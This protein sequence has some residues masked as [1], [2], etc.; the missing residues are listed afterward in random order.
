[1]PWVRPR[2]RRAPGCRARA[3][4]RG[5]RCGGLGRTGRPG[6]RLEQQGPQGPPR[7][8]WP[9]ARSRPARSRSSASAYGSGVGR[10]DRPRAATADAASPRHPRRSDTLVGGA[11]IA[12]SANLLNLLDLRPG[13]ALKATIVLGAPDCRRRHARR[14]AAG[15]AAGA[16]V[17]CCGRTSPVRRCWATPAP[18]APGALL[19]AALVQ[20]TGRRG[21]WPP[22][23]SWR[24]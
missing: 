20:R 14:A 4:A 7:V 19:G 16:A 2:A 17:G 13:R 11:V 15:A 23:A 6:G 21:R 1:M 18:T 12:G 5:G 24:R 8:P 10:S 22:W 9:A 3:G